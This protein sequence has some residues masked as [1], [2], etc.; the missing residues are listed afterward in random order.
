MTSPSTLECREDVTLIA[1]DKMQ[2]APVYRSDGLKVG[3]IELVMTDSL[4]GEVVYAVMSC[5][6]GAGQDRYPLPWSLLVP[7]FDGYEANI[8]DGQL[9]GAPK[10]CRN[11]SWDWASREQ[12]QILSDYYNVPPM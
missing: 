3:Q 6:G 12:G 7:A 8:T 2:G 5:S 11:E 4:S 1:S 9:K 10:Y